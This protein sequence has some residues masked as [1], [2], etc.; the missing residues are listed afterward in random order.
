MHNLLNLAVSKRDCTFSNSKPP[1]SLIA[2]TP[3]NPQKKSKCHQLRRNSPSVIDCNPF[4]TCFVKGIEARQTVPAPARLFSELTR[5][6]NLEATR[7]FYSTDDEL[8]DAIAEA[9]QTIIQD[10]YCLISYQSSPSCVIKLD[11]T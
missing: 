7:K 3:F 4:S 6:E 2:S 9:Y 11:G 10:L 5:K 8:I 1:A